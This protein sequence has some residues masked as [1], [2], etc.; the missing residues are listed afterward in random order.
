MPITKKVWVIVDKNRMVM[1]MGQPRQRELNFITAV[2][3]SQRI[4]TYGTKKRAQTG[5]TGSG[6]YSSKVSEYLLEQY[7]YGGW[8]N[9]KDPRYN[10]EIKFKDFL[11]AV[12]AEITI[13]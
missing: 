1:G 8:T 7:G 10:K 4:L 11:E 9:E 12:E 6:F 5:F 2:D 13:P 3:G